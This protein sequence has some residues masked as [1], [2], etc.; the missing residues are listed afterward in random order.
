MAKGYA[1]WK[2]VKFGEVVR[3]NKETC[4]DP[5]SAGIERV[6]GLEHLEP[7]DLRVRSWGEVA[8]GTTFT[9]RVRPGQV[10]FGKR[11]AYQRKVAVA[12]FD[13]ICSGDIYVFES[14]APERLIPE[15]LPFV[16]Q[17][18][19]FFEHAVGTSAGSLSP[20]TSWLSLAAYELTLPPLEEQR[21]IAA[22][23]QAI[24][25]VVERAGD[26]AD[27]AAV[28]YQATRHDAFQR[29]LTDRIARRSID[30]LANHGG[31][32]DG[33]FGSNLKSEHWT[34]SGVPVVQ[35]QHITS[36]HFRMTVPY[37]VSSDTFHELQRCDAQGGDI[38]MVKKGINCGACALLDEDHPRS[39]LSSNCMRIRVLDQSASA[40]FVAQY[41]H[42]YRAQGRFEGL[43]GS[44]Q[45]RATTLREVRRIL[46]PTPPRDLQSVLLDQLASI[47]AAES[48]LRL[49]KNSADAMLREAARALA[50]GAA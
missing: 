43:I 18:D 12:E 19:A 6:V 24:R 38:V 20:R 3:L 39:L 26:A 28:A 40:P 48:A 29:M 14:V 15:L 17:T 34:T 9:N 42:W 36:G 41:L 32:V 33:P 45:Q 47:E 8:D 2:R 4:K 25:A 1:T 13:A 23:L 49:G 5:A 22:A 10:L 35:S 31:V 37:F 50:G 30:D 27:Q 16:C 11:R 7:G 46:V 21:R 44:T